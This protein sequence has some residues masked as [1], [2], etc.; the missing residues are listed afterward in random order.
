[1]TDS[2]DT[3]ALE[4]LVHPTYGPGVLAIAATPRPCRI[5]GAPVTTWFCG[6]PAH[7]GCWENAGRPGLPT[8]DPTAP[9]PAAAPASTTPADVSETAGSDTDAELSNWARV[10]RAREEWADATDAQCQAALAAWHTHVTYQGRPARWASAPS[11]TGLLIFEWLLAQRPQMVSPTA[12][13]TEDVVA[14]T[15][16]GAVL[17]TLAFLDSDQVPTVG[18]GVTELDVNAQYLAAARS[19]ELGDGEPEQLGPVTPDNLRPLLARPGWV[20]LGDVPDLTGLPITARGPLARIREG[21]WLPA[22]MARYLTRDHDVTLDVAAAWTWPTGQ[23]GR[24]LDVWCA[25]IA[26]A[27]A[28]LTT[29]KAGGDAAAAIALGMLKAMYAAT[30]GGM[31]RSEQH[32]RSHSFRPDWTDMYV[33]QANANALRAIDKALTATRDTDNAPRLLG[34]MRDSAWWMADTAPLTA[35]ALADALVISGQPGKWHVNRWGPVTEALVSAHQT[36]RVGLVRK[37]ITQADTDRTT[38]TAGVD[39]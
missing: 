30:L 39:Q 38:T 17:R 28:S 23:H 15:R 9:A 21:S 18:D 2:A 29:A 19:T 34:M 8:A 10:V 12:L 13:Q 7:G 31:L 3:P 1:M 36:G 35:N 27:R 11:A 6:A 33:A 4:Y 26:D 37:A 14:L 32:N 24:R 22:P 16:D 20:Q 5:C 25:A